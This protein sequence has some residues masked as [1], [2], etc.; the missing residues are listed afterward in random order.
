MAEIQK[1]THSLAERGGEGRDREREREKKR[2]MSSVHLNGK[3]V[4]SCSKTKIV[5]VN[6]V[7][8]KTSTK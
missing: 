5:T 6:H 3:K 4:I 8:A 1:C 7:R 2:V